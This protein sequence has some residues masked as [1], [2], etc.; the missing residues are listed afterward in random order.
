[1]T[2]HILFSAFTLLF[3]T[4]T[5]QIAKVDVDEEKYNTNVTD[6]VVVFAMHFDIGY[7][8]WAEGVLQDYAGSMLEKTLTSIEETSRLP[9]EEQFVWTIPGWPMKYMLENTTDENRI[10]LEN[11][12]RDQR[13]IT[14][15]L[16]MCHQT[17]AS[18]L[19]NLVRGISYATEISTKYNVPKA[20]DAKLT[21]IPSHSRVL[22]TLLKN[23]GVDIL[24]LGCNPGST[25]PDVPEI[26]WWEGPDR[27]RLLTFYWSRYY[28]SDILPPKDWSHKTWLAMIHSHENTGAPSPEEVAELLKKAKEKMPNAQVRI[29]RISDFYD[30]LMKEEPDLPVIT[31]DMP[32]TWIHGYMSMPEETKLSKTLQRETYNT[33]ILNTQLSLWTGSSNPVNSYIDEAVENMLLYDEHT[34]G[35]AMTHGN[36]HKWTFGDEFRINKSLG[37]YDYIE[38]SWDEKSSRIKKAERIIVPLMNRKLDQLAASV[39]TEG[40]R[41]IVYNPLPWKRNGRVKF[42][43]GVY[44]KDFTI[45]GLKDPETDKTIPVYEDYNLISFDAENVPATGYKTYI[46]LLTPISSNSSVALNETQGLLENKYFRLRIDT[47]TGA[48]S[49]AFDKQSQKELVDQHS[50][51]GFASYLYELAGQDQIDAYNKNYIK[52]GA[53]FW[54]TP[55]MIRQ[56]VPNEKQELIRGLPEKTVFKN[57]GNAVRATVFGRIE[58]PVSQDYLVTYTLYE[59]QPYVEINWGIDGKKPNPE[60]EAGWLAFPFNLTDPEYR[61]YR[62]GGIVDPQMEFVEKTNQDFYF[63]NTSMTMF[64]SNGGGIGLNTPDAPGISIDNPGLFT[65]SKKKEL[66]TGKVFVNLYNNQWGT[67][68]T[69]WI[70]GSF[71]A[72]VYLWS[73][74][75]YDA[76]ENFITPSEETRAPLKG[77]YYDGP[78]GDLSLRQEGISLDQKGT[79]VTSFGKQP[80]GNGY[81]L[82]LWEQTGR[83]SSVSVKLPGDSTFTE[84]F[85]CD[86]TGEIVDNQGISIV[87]NRFRFDI[88]PNQ[89][90]T[91]LLR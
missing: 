46:P 15:A 40:K 38:G 32:D 45:F 21:D 48:L 75:K 19:E 90:V 23:S 59:D 89:P 43:A 54:A 31:Q 55:E 27:S 44:R 63:L 60:P 91:F 18:D 36:Q 79:I 30:L 17:E 9:K 80:T 76:E 50:E 74:G 34:F 37:N 62:T 64:D 70:E 39:E 85:R 7:T 61:L 56:S 86:L 20:R 24:H 83:G 16:P 2:R 14:H 81:I 71:S 3:F 68:F 73:Y 35:I 33:E 66:S 77:V 22:P 51:M 12:I 65:Y 47:S 52:P 67:N 42:F 1:M 88:Q 25:S 28:G 53:E 5:G 13:I 11:A 69:E 8:N 10:R 82:R 58:G 72:K 29:G 6:I 78:M 4:C 26:F 57:M 41:I 84:A 87:E 49:S